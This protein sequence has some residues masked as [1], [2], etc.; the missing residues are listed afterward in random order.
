MQSRK[1]SGTPESKYNQ[2]FAPTS[3]IYMEPSLLSLT[4]QRTE[5]LA[6]ILIRKFL[7]LIIER[8][9]KI[10]QAFNEF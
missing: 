10:N 4:P 2:I 6:F 3:T 8:H 5:L 7:W 1:A 9:S